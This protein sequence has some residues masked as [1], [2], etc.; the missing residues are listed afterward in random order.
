MIGARL[1]AMCSVV[2]VTGCGGGGRDTSPETPSVPAPSIA[3]ASSATSVMPNGAAVEITPT[4]TGVTGP[5]TWS[6]TPTASIGTTLYT[7][8]DKPIAAY[9]PPWD[10]KADKVTITASA[11]GI[12]G[13][14][15]LSVKPS[16]VAVPWV[17]LPVTWQVVFGDPPTLAGAR[18]VDSAADQSGNLYLAYSSP[19]SEIKK[20]AADGRIATYAQ[21]N[22]PIS[23]AYAPDGVLYVVDSLGSLAY[24]IRRISADGRISTL[25]QTAPYDAAT[26]AIDGSSGVATAYTLNLA[27]A[28]GGAVYATDGSKVRKIAPDGTFSTLA[29][30]G[31]EAGIPPGSGCVD[32]RNPVDGVGVQARFMGPDDIVADSAGNLYV[33]DVMLIRKITPAGAV[34]T[35]AGRTNWT[36]DFLNDIDGT[37]NA[38]FFAGGGPMAIDAAGNLYKLGSRG[39]LRKITPSGVAST[40]ATSLGLTGAQP[41]NRIVALHAVSPGVV[42]LQSYAQLGK[43][44]VD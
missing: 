30:G 44:R 19:V 29:G 5:L 17:T 38:A 15:E 1:F 2:L 33:N 4:L 20:V 12:S 21:V 16:P 36:F 24:A 11:G 3:L 23:L 39:V 26:G 9:S 27:V 41:Q 14:V 22:E 18:P 35:L 31:C 42:M 28:P 37:G 7:L 40:V 6:V 25:T 10:L 43:V 32:R 13:S 34:T 8:P